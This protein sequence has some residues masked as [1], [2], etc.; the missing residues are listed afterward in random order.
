MLELFGNQLDFLMSNSLHNRNIQR[1]NL[2]KPEKEYIYKIN[3]KLSYK[4]HKSYQYRFSYGDIQQIVLEELPRLDYI[5]V[6]EI[7]NYIASCFFDST[8]SLTFAYKHKSFQ[9]YFFYSRDNQA[10]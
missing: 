5:A 8:D 9:E 6:K 1:L 2:P 10:I 7:I 3:R 4:L